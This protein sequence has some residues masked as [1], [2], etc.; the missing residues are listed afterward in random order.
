MSSPDARGRRARKGR[1]LVVPADTLL[2]FSRY[3][4]PAAPRVPT[5]S[6][7]PSRHSARCGESV[8][9]ASHRFALLPDVANFVLHAALKPVEWQLVELVFVVA[10]RQCPICLNAVCVPRI[11]PCGHVF[12][13]VCFLQHLSF[14]ADPNGCA[15]CPLCSSPVSASDLRACCFVSAEEMQLHHTCR[16]TLISSHKQTLIA[17]PHR[18]ARRHHE[19]PTNVSLLKPFFS[20]FAT[21]DPD[22]L[23]EL[24]ASDM[25]QLRRILR[26]DASLTPFVNASMNELRLKKEQ[27]RARRA[28][29]VQQQRASSE[30]QNTYASE[31]WYFYQASDTTNVFLHPVNHR[32]LNTEFE[33]NFENA[34][35]HIEGEVLQIHRH[36]MDDQVRKRYR[37]LSHL[38]NGCEFSFVELDLTALLSAQTLNTHAQE[39]KERERGRKRLQMVSRKEDRLRERHESQQMKRYVKN[40]RTGDSRMTGGEQQQT[41]DGTDC[42]SFPALN[43]GEEVGE[44]RAKEEGRGVWGS[45]ISSY[46]SV[47]SNMG[48]FPALGETGGAMTNVRSAAQGAWATTS[49]DCVAGSSS[50]GSVARGSRRQRRGHGKCTIVVSSNAGAQHRR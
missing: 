43:E 1:S 47:T 6:N 23:L 36:T 42:V 18:D 22:F 37:F 10:K 32:C 16:M 44:T 5:P 11:T 17:V 45:D 3:S 12:D 41:V 15:P 50:D 8:V 4:P 48:L 38:A 28:A 21:A 24:I 49:A 39:L 19:L 46:S 25:R 40:S 26:E 9:Q 29:S 27:Y 31:L 34:P 2:N 13:L 30:N 33:C 35:R 7:V 14:S 20:R